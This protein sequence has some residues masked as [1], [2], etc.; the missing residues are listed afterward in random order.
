MFSTRTVTFD[1]VTVFGI[2]NCRCDV[3]GKRMRRQRRFTATINPWNTNE[4]GEIKTRDEILVGLKGKRKAWLDQP[5]KHEK[6][7]K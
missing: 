3:C 7:T 2:K 4:D 5:E 6:C 1:E